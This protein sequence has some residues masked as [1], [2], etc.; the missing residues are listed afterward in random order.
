MATLRIEEALGRL[1]S[2]FLEMPG[3]QLTLTDATRLTGLDHDTCRVIL[4]ALEDVR[5]LRRRNN[6]TFIQRTS[7]SPDL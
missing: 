5:F 6:G 7:E 3:T 2:T 1:K 4:A